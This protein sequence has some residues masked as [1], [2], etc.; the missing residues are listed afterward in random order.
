MNDR[1]NDLFTNLLKRDL[2][3]LGR[4]L[5]SER[6]PETL[7]AEVLS[8]LG[9]L[10]PQTVIP[11]EGKIPQLA[12]LYTAW[13]PEPALRRPALTLLRRE[14]RLALLFLF[15][16]DG[17]VREAALDSF[18]APPSLVPRLKGPRNEA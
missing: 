17:Y 12:A 8:G 2:A 15:H 13:S 9:A 18:G 16:R 10:P 7:L 1:P 11:G 3:D 6:V 14:P 5:A 4:A